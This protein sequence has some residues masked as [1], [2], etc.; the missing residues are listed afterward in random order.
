MANSSDPGSC[1]ETKLQELG[2]RFVHIGVVDPEG[3]FRDKL[4][5]ADKA[6]KLARKG[7]PFCEVLYFW[8]I[9]EKTHSETSF[10][11]R[12]ARLFPDT[13][14]AYPFADHTAVCLADFV[15]EFGRRSPRNLCLGQIAAAAELGFE[16]HSAFEF[17]FFVFDETAET[18]RAKGYRDLKPFAPGNR[19]Y[20]LQTSALYGD[21]LSGLDATMATLGITLDAIHT[22][23]GPGC[24]E[25]PIVHAKGIR[26]PDDAVLFKTFTRAYF[27]RCDKTVSFMSK[28]SP[29][30]S[31]QSG[32]LHVSLRDVHGRALF[33]DASAPEGL[34]AIARQFIGGLLKLM[35]E[36]LAL[37]SST[38]NAYKRLTPGAWAPTAANWGVQNRTAAV[39]VI[40]D[41]AESTR[42][43][44]RVPSADANPYLALAMALGAGLYG[45]R[46]AVEPPPGGDGNFYA[47]EPA[48]D[49]TFPRDL[50]EAA[51]RLRA[52]EAARTAF[53]D[54]FVDSFAASREIE[55]AEYQKQVSEWEL[56]RYLGVV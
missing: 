20:S 21:L 12:P 18:I 5:S 6:I 4:V 9:A 17:E 27:G 51:E 22:E 41:D 31:G 43:E 13:V 32:H 8:D 37:C 55:Y 42:I 24:F 48:I 40:N 29:A 39:R 46:N 28:L 56:R 54:T 50:R 25:A 3:E 15:G 1:L 47:A 7:Y 52:S 23:L 26:A 16:V 45:V 35:P 19:T 2:A 14:R 38:V 36:W 10:V 53:G 44:F 33:A 30:L 34:S 49:S 11:D